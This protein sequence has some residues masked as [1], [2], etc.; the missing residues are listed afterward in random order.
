MSQSLLPQSAS[1]ETSADSGW[2][3]NSS[4]LGNKLFKW[5]DRVFETWL[6]QN[7]GFN[8][9]AWEGRDEMAN[10][11]AEKTQMQWIHEKFAFSVV[12]IC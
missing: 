9:R 2:E 7:N 4:G 10:Q 8:F 12:E 5:T 6:S 1:E 3:Y 11:N